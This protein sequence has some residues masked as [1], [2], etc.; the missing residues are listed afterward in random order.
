MTKYL[1]KASNFHGTT[2]QNAVLRELIFRVARYN[3]EEPNQNLL[4]YI[5]STDTSLS[6][7][8]NQFGFVVCWKVDPGVIVATILKVEI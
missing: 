8:Q 2:W 6:F 1:V 7:S 5:Y 3:D 4:H